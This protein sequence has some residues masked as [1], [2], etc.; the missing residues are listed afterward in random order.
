MARLFAAMLLPRHVEAH[1]DE[2]V[3]AA[4]SARPDLRWVPPARWHITLE[5]IGDCGPHEADRQLNRWARRA[6]RSGPMQL[7]F[8]GAGTF[9]RAWMARVLWMGLGGDLPAWR[10]LAGYQQDAHMTLARTRER[11]DL[12]GLAD[13]LSAYDGPSWTVTEIALVESHLRGS[14]D[15][16]PRYEPLELFTLGEKAS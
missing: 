15:R 5:F 2:F 3:D 7:R 4:R 14:N 9:P 8:H 11:T 6:A 1:L 16:G 13:E 12:T 10:K